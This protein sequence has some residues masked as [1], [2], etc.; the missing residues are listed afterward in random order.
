MTNAAVVI[1]ENSSGKILSLLGSVDY[2]DDSI[3]GKNNMATAIRQPGS[4]IKPVTYAAAFRKGIATPATPI[5]DVPKVYFTKKGEGFLPHNY[6][7][8][9]RGR[10]LAR[11]ALASSYNLPAVEMLDRVGIDEFLN[12]SYQMGITSM[13]E[14]ENYDLALTLGGGSVSLQELT[15]LYATFAR[16]GKWIP[17]RL[18]SKVIGDNGKV[19]YESTTVE[20]KRVLDAKV[21]WLIT[22][23]LS[24]K[25]ARIPTFGEKNALVLTKPAAVKTGTTTDWH[26]NWTIGYTPDY[27]VGVWVGNSDNHPMKQIS[28]VTGAAPIWNQIFE[29]LLKFNDSSKFVRPD[30]ISEAEICAWDGLLANDFCTERYKEVFIEGTEPKEVSALRQ[31]PNFAQGVVQIISPRQGATFE[32]GV[33]KDEAIIF[34]ISHVPNLESLEW[35]LDGNKIA[36]RK[37]TQFTCAWTPTV[38]EHEVKAIAINENG[39][40]PLTPVNFKVLEYKEGMF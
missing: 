29:E 1:L 25:K 2:F 13:K 36:C 22:D 37:V 14:T 31:K 12:L 4:S 38:G 20:P 17:T 32:K 23:I 30:G 27:T 21:A 5:D 7:G 35:E 34:E 10:V 18:I 15:N 28:G 39:E 8:I 19:L 33:A 3:Q 40:M 6:D 24:D 16:E 26:D 9:Y 11:E